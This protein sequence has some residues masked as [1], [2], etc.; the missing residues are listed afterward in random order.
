MI[1]LEFEEDSK[2]FEDI[3]LCMSI[4]SLNFYEHRF[5]LKYNIMIVIVR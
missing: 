5:G 2:E 1:G 3:E 4:N